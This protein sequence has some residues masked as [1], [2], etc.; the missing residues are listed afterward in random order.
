MSQLTWYRI[1]RALQGHH[2]ADR[3]KLAAL[4]FDDERAETLAKWRELGDKVEG[5]RMTEKDRLR[6]MALYLWLEADK[7]RRAALRQEQPAANRP[8]EPERE[9]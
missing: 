8:R 2:A 4:G 5:G 3:E 1:C 7:E 6:E 9:R